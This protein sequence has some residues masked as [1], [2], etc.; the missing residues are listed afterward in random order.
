[1]RRRYAAVGN[2][3]HP[4]RQVPLRFSDNRPWQGLQPKRPL[5]HEKSQRADML[6]AGRGSTAHQKGEPPRDGHQNFYLLRARE[7]R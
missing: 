4:G 1:M 3:P 7:D 2:I 6:A 5:S